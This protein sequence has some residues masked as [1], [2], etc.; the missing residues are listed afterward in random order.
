MSIQNKVV[1]GTVEKFWTGKDGRPKDITFCV[2]EDCNLAC[3]YCYM[4]GKN[5]NKKMTFETAKKAVDCILADKEN[6][7]SAS[8]VWDFI[9]GE[10]FLEIE[11]IDKITDYIKL[12]M[13]TLDH[14]WFNSYRLNFSTNGILYDTPAVQA[15]IKK[16]LL[17]LS[18][19]FSVDGNKQKHDLQRVYRDGK[20]SYDDVARNVPLWLSQFPHG[21]TKATFSHDDLPYLKDSI[22]SLWNIG[23]KKVAANVV[24]EDVWEEDDDKIM[25][26]QLKDLADYVIENKLWDSCSV[27]FFE[28]TIGKPLREEDK[29]QNFCGA[30]YMLAI[31]CDG[32]FTPCI[33][34][35][36]ISLNH[37]KPI[38]IGNVNEGINRDK[39]RPFLALNMKAQS[40]QEC[41]DC[42]VATGCGWC[43]GF[44]YDT[45]ETSTIYQR[46]TYLCKIHKATIRA[47]KYFWNKF[48]RVTGIP[49][50]RKDLSAGYQQ[51]DIYMQFIT[52]DQ[53]MPHCNY[54][55]SK[56]SDKVMSKEVFEAGVSFCDDNNIA[57]VLLGKPENIEPKQYEYYLIIDKAGNE[58]NTISIYENGMEAIEDGM[59]D[60]IYRFSRQK[61]NSLGKNI[62]SLL[63][64][65]DRIN[66]VI[67]DMEEWNA[68]DVEKYKEQMDEIVQYLSQKYQRGEYLEINRLTDLWDIQKMDNCEAGEKTFALAPNGKIYICPAFYFENPDNYIGTLEDGI[69]IKNGQLLKAESAPICGICDVYSCDRC[70]FLNQKLTNEINTPSHIQCLIS[71]VEREASRKLQNFIKEKTDYKFVNELENIDYSDPY[72]KIFK[73]KGWN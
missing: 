57:P 35:F 62:Q 51:E 41:L 1:I 54:K 32:N 2:T 72:E 53:I 34:F 69:N 61:I 30:G 8:V 45:A 67:E 43:Q 55:S 4:S 6:L 63:K 19:G 11:L 27:R 31:D 70:K 24:F 52:S 15:Y 50:F 14:P 5:H 9:G 3:K 42:D 13:F 26:S 40:K 33:R 56:D 65:K 73:L 28:P 47:N 23:I 12:R 29:E 22:I 58:G 25:E 21:T 44:N 10:P 59:S 64:N 18:V 71:H 49:S 68:A 60:G 48:E 46:A 37:R 66:L 20:G 17:H 7:K 36:N 16:N 39:I 38:F